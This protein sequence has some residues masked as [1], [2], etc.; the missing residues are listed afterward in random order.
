MKVKIV[1]AGAECDIVAILDGD[2]CPAE[3]F[4]KDGEAETEG[5]RAG[6]A[7]ILQHV[8]EKGIQN[9][10]AAWVH[11]A[12]KKDKINEFI[13]GPLRLF[14]FKGKGRQIAVCTTGARKKGNK[15]DKAAV[16]KAAA[17]RKKYEQ[18]VEDQTLEVI[19]DEDE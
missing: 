15:A 16:K 9:V 3:D 14:F 4:I 2:D 17:L 13:K 12:N 7:L 8:A 5:A 18:A 19:N 10:P 1:V 11:E 6:L